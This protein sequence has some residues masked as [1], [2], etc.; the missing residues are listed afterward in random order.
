[1]SKNK[2]RL[3]KQKI[4]EKQYYKKV[5]KNDI[6]NS[7]IVFYDE[8]NNVCD[9]EEVLDSYNKNVQIE[10]RFLNFINQKRK[11]EYIDLLKDKESLKYNTY[12]NRYKND[13]PYSIS[14]FQEKKKENL[15]SFQIEL[16]EN[17]K[18]ED[19][20]KEEYEK[21]INFADNKF[22]NKNFNKSFNKNKFISFLMENKKEIQNKYLDTIEILEEDKKIEYYCR[23]YLTK[24]IANRIKSEIRLK[25]ENEKIK[26]F[27]NLN[28]IVKTLSEEEIVKYMLNKLRMNIIDKN[29]SMYIVNNKINNSEQ[30]EVLRQEEILLKKFSEIISKANTNLIKKRNQEKEMKNFDIFGGNY[31][32]EGL[33]KSKSIYATEIYRELEELWAIND[34]NI[35]DEIINQIVVIRSMV[36]HKKKKKHHKLSLKSLN[37][38]KNTD[39]DKGLKKD[40]FNYNKVILEKYISNSVFHYY[41]FSKINRIYDQSISLKFKFI[42]SNYLPRFSKILKRLDYDKKINLI[43]FEITQKNAISFLYKEIYYNNFRKAIDQK[44]LNVN[45]MKKVIEEYKEKSNKNLKLEESFLSN[46]HSVEYKKVSKEVSSGNLK[47]IATIWEMY[48]SRMFLKFI[49]EEKFS[50]KE[51]IE[52]KDFNDNLLEELKSKISC[53]EIDFLLEKEEFI[54]IYFLLKLLNRREINEF[55]NTIKSLWQFLNSEQIEK[56][57]LNKKEIENIYNLCCI[58]IELV[59]RKN[60]VLEKNIS[61]IIN[62]KEFKILNNILEDIENKK[63]YEDNKNKI[64]FKYLRIIQEENTPILFESML[65]NI[66]K[67]EYFDNYNKVKESLSYNQKKV[68]EEINDIKNRIKVKKRI[69]KDRYK[70]EIRNDIVNLWNEN[71]ENNYNI[72][73]VELFSIRKIQKFIIEIYS[74]YIRTIQS[75]ERDFILLIEFKGEPKYLRKKEKEIQKYIP[76]N[77]VEEY[78]AIR[79]SIAHYNYFN[80]ENF[81]KSLKDL[82]NKIF[83]ILEYNS[84][85]KKSF[86][87][88]LEYIFE[89]NN[90]IFINKNIFPQKHQYA[91]KGLKGKDKFK[92]NNTD[93]NKLSLISDKELNLFKKVFEYKKNKC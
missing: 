31:K 73:M 53:K 91:Y 51:K 48:I 43:D 17:K 1:M 93:W 30:L 80:D 21:V 54:I 38:I 77:I 28:N 88:S 23:L 57:I 64:E 13:I 42:S 62:E 10:K 2:F 84:K 83:S 89:K 22:F 36:I 8:T 92:E 46:K 72:N 24:H 74:L 7:N 63:F 82:Y 41:D 67:K 70:E 11:K 12:I 32:L 87:L 47:D 85:R 79:N 60:I 19:L 25:V 5:E 33:L 69:S 56:I 4:N 27:K 6:G 76:N 45:L 58:V 9:I 78:F 26:S 59:D 68:S 14:Y 35:V 20:V 86:R 37:K 55:M 34:N 44:N 90:M 71:L 39:I 66:V 16:L 50:F 18:Y 15:L 3:T 61:N 40:I 81:D 52:K 65:K 75:I 29:K 49:E